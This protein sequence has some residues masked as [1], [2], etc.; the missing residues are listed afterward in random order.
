MPV[1]YNQGLVLPKTS[2]VGIQVD[3]AAPTFGWRDIIGDVRPKTSGAGTPTLSTW[4][5]GQV[6]MYSFA[7]NDVI[8]FTFHIPHDYVPGSDMF[9][10][11]HWGHNGTATSGSF[12]AD[13]YVTYAK[14]HNQAGFGVE[15]V[16]AITPTK[17]K[18][19]NFYA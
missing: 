1:I 11:L 6:Q 7:V 10:H 17:N 13:N 3:P 8:D 18:A 19:P 4:I 15:V 16:K 2:G 9:F 5:G 14:G 12:A